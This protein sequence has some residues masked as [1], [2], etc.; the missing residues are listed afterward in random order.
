MLWPALLALLTAAPRPPLA[1]AAL[2]VG[3]RAGRGSHASAGAL[4]DLLRFD[5]GTILIEAPPS[6]AEGVDPWS[7]FRVSDGDAEVGWCSAEGSPTGGAFVFELETDARLEKLRIHDAAAQ[8]KDYPGISVK[9]LELWG[10][11]ASGPFRKIATFQGPRG[12]DKEFPVPAGAPVRRVKLVVRSNH[13]N[14]SYTEIMDLDVLGKKVG[15][16]PR[17]NMTGDYYSEEWQGL[18]LEQHG[19]QLEGCYASGEGSISGEVLGRVAQVRWR[20][21]GEQGEMEGTATFVAGPER[22]HLRG[23]YRQDGALATRHPQGRS[24]VMEEPQP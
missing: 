2:E 7:A 24:S 17:V 6:F 23:V 16:A 13:G 8:E 9:S 1:V 14:P 21:R 4:V 3:G 22:N 18:R 15:A 5:Q 11:G 12:A 19:T 10:A 20:Q